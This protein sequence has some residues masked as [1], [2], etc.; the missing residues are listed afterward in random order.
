V[1]WQG[2]WT[3]E[4]GFTLIELTIVITLMGL[5]FAIASSTWFGVI[6]SRRVD[7]ATNQL[8]A[9]LRLAHSK[10]TNRLASQTVTLDADSSEYPVTGDGTRDL[11][12]DPDEDLVVVDTS[13]DLTFNASGSATLPGGPSSL[14]FIVRSADDDPDDPCPD[15]DDDPCHD[16]EINAATSRVQIDP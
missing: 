4:R 10:A 5:L 1:R 12:D 6:E 13:A 9:D 11:D 15:P 14:T 3:D 8:A 2:T 16:I 7:S